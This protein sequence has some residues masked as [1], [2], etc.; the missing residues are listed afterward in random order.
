MKMSFQF[1]CCDINGIKTIP[2]AICAVKS[3]VPAL[4]RPWHV[5]IKS[6]ASTK[7]AENGT[8]RSGFCKW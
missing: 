6:D 2:I 3:S 8:C 4:F 1:Y 7:L 5:K